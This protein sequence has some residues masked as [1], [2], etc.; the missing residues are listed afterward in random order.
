[1]RNDSKFLRVVL[2]LCLAG[3]FISGWLLST[4]IR[5]STGQA[6]L[7]ESCSILSSSHSQGCANVA[8]SAYSDVFGIPLAAIALGY[9]FTVLLLVFWAM[10]NFQQSYEALYVT[11]FLSTLSII[12]TVIM[13]SISRFVLNSFCIGCAGLWTVNLLLWPAMVKQLG[14]SWGNALAGN[15]ELIRHK[16]LQL[17]QKRILNCFI[18]GGVCLIVFSVIGTAA[19]GLSN[20]E[21]RA[22]DAALIAEYQNAVQVFL[23][24]EAFGGPQSKGLKVENGKTPVMDIVEFADFQCP[25]CKMAGQYFKPFVM[26]HSDKVRLSFRHFPLDGSCNPHAANG[27]HMVACIAAKAATCAGRQDRFF[28]L[29]DQIYDHQ[30]ELTSSLI[31]ELAEKAGLDMAQ[32]KSCQADKTVDAQMR[33]EMEWANMINLESTPTVVINGRKLVGA[34]SPADLEALLNFLEKA[35]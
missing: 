7:T 8:V 15:L 21:S 27:R 19:K 9:Y 1:M 26:K 18:L 2:I 13:F 32:Y 35:K 31:D 4:H 28:A 33:N 24:A 14:L 6:G 10:R 29:H 23:P 17:Q 34:R 5:F 30:E 20:E 11:F 3:I 22:G 16:N 25:A 12:V